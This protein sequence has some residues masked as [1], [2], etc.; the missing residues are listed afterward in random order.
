MN[1]EELKR[2]YNLLNNVLDSDG[3]YQELCGKYEYA[4]LKCLDLINGALRNE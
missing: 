4:I 3:S 1:K 2:I